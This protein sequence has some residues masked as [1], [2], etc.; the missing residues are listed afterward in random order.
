MA[1]LLEI[2]RVVLIGCGATLL[3]DLWLMVLKR[4]GV[5]TLKFAFIGRWVGH[6]LRGRVAHASIAAAAPV[7]NEVLLG[8]LTH[9]AVGIAF[10]LLLVGLVGIDWA[11][12]PTLAPA[13]AFGVG[14]VAFPFLVMQPAMGLGIAASK[15]AT[16]L[17]NVLRSLLNHFVFGLGLFLSARF[18]EWVSR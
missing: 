1:S 6:L 17:R 11:T 14:T 10:A 3:M 9:Y 13:V 8:W 2:S 15:T 16:P 12:A 4:A 18:I 5:P 7:R